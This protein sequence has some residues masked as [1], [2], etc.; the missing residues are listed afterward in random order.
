M[1][2]LKRQRALA[3]GRPVPPAD[4]NP[5]AFSSRCVANFVGSNHTHVTNCRKAVAFA[6]LDFHEKKFKEWVHVP[7]VDWFVIQLAIDETESYMLVK[8][9]DNVFSLLMLHCRVRRRMQNGDVDQ[10][11]VA[12]P[13]ATVDDTTAE[14]MTSAINYV[15]SALE[16]ELKTSTATVVRVLNSDKAKSLVKVG[17]A[18]SRKVRESD[19]V[20]E[21]SLHGHCMMHMMWASLVGSISTYGIASDLYCSSLLLRRA[22]NISTIAACMKSYIRQNL[23]RVFD[24]PPDIYRI[25]NDAI[26]NL[27]DVADGR[28]G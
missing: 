9:E 16:T 23:Q 25:R 17:R 27:M 1:N 11:D 4:P 24:P 6:I 13:P 10:I 21:A 8:N 2:I 15:L 5:G 3:E 19:Q 20:G 14:S 28:A 7:G 18:W 26:I 22:H 12:M